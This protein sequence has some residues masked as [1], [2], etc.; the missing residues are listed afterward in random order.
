MLEKQLEKN[1]LGTQDKG[2]VSFKGLLEQA[3]VKGVDLSFEDV[4]EI[5]KQIQAV[6]DM[7]LG[8]EK[9]LKAPNGKVTKLTEGQWLVVRTPNFKAWFGDWEN[10]PRE[11][12]KAVDQETG[13]PKV[14]FHGGARSIDMF[15]S[16]ADRTWD[17][18]DNHG[19]YFSPNSEASSNFAILK[20]E[21]IKDGAAVVY[22]V[23]LCLRNPKE[24]TYSRSFSREQKEALL[25][26]GFDGA[27]EIG[28]ERVGYY[29]DDIIVVFEA[30]Q[31]KSAVGNI[32][33]FNKD[34]K[35]M[36]L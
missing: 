17:E 20:S 32:G 36:S 3:K 11:A 29:Q 14:Y 34:S 31:V 35:D 6:K 12:S 28:G 8:T 25:G 22:P 33:T 13:E 2:D 1:A 16:L 15:K 24:V 9:W 27:I 4:K 21:K 23:F 26:D 18:Y 30:S 7:Y 10:N 19:I 5:Q